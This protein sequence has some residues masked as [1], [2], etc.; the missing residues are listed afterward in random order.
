MK[1]L[2]NNV[3]VSQMATPA[4]ATATATS[5]AVDAQGFNSLAVLFDVGQSGDT[6]SG[7][8]FWTLKLTECDTS[9]GSYTDVAAED[10]Y[11]SAATVVIDDAAEDEVIVKFGYKGSKRFIKAVATTTGTHTNGTP[12]SIIAMQGHP[13]NAPV[14]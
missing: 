11:N 1:D 10:L 6:L 5:T 7:S 3:K 13:V 14:A 2:Y 12:L 4:V 9:G 8:V